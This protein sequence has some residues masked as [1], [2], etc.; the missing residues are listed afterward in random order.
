MSIKLMSAIFDAEFFDLEYVKDGEKRKAKASTCK[1]VLLAIADHANDFGESA[2][3]GY[4]KLEIK[5]ALSR[6]GLSDTIEALK[7]NGLLSVDEKPSRLQ[8]NNYTINVRSLPA[9]AKELPDIISES[10]HLTSGSQAT[11]LV[12]VKP[13]DSIHPLTTNKPSSDT[14]DKIISALQSAGIFSGVGTADYLRDWTSEHEDAWIIKAIEK[15]KGKN[16]KYIDKIL[17]D[18]KANGYPKSRQEQIAGA[19][20]IQQPAA[21]ERVP[22]GV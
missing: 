11:L 19:K 2:Y 14:T 16:M 20:R 1:L 4:S 9:I 3:P 18:W 6:Q 8:T 5:T 15:G 12:P 10:S 21:Y 7:Y 22:S 13:L 17:L